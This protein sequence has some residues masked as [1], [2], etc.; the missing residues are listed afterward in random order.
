[1]HL[2]LIPPWFETPNHPTAGK[3]VKDLAFALPRHGLKVN[4]LFQSGENLP[5]QSTL[6]HDIAVWHSHCT[7]KGKLFPIWNTISIRAY[8]KVFRAYIHKH[9]LPDLIHIHGYT[10]LPIATYIKK[11]FN[12]PFV[13]TEH[14]STVLQNKLN[15][16]E[17]R[18]I[19]WYAHQAAAITA[20]SA[21][22]GDRLHA[23]CTSSVQIIPNTIDFDYFVPRSVVR[24]DDLLM[25]NLLNKNKQV[26]LGIRVFER[27]CDDH[28]QAT[29]HIIGDGPERNVLQD[30]ANSTKDRATVI[31]HGEKASDYW[32]PILQTA[33]CLLSLSKSETFGVTVLEALACKTPVVALNNQGINEI[34]PLI[35]LVLLP[36]E[37]NAAMIYTALI[38]AVSQPVTTEQRDKLKSKFDYNTVAQLYQSIYS[39]AIQKVQ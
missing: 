13:Y 27:W 38:Q 36:L 19:K 23:L 3:A 22:L 25:I 17:Q 30:L 12:I 7:I 31:F 29:L 37:S 39:K 18:I 34:A 8:I 32:L 5:L 28:P 16:I 24:S 33:A 2:V 4:L 20:V 6:Q 9:G 21:A 10:C 15:I 11:K 14:S 26:D 35:D 1:M